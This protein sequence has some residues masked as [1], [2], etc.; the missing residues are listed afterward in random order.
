METFLAS[1]TAAEFYN[2]VWHFAWM[3]NVVHRLKGSEKITCC[4]TGFTVKSSKVYENVLLK[5]CFIP[6]GL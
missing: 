4:C 1:E 2:K 6:P 3:L 5:D